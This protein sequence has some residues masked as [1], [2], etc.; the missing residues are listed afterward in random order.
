MSSKELHNSQGVFFTLYQGDQIKKDE[1]GAAC[2]AR[3]GTERGVRLI[4]QLLS[5][6]DG[7]EWMLTSTPCERRL[8]PGTKPL[9]SHCWRLSQVVRTHRDYYSL[10]SLRGRS[11]MRSGFVRVH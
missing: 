10:A 11:V 1:M 2:S 3:K 7:N 5:Y 4:I 8:N 6:A 9:R